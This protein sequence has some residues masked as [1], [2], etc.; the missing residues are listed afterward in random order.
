MPHTTMPNRSDDSEKTFL[1]ICSEAH[2]TIESRKPDL[3]PKVDFKILFYC[4]K[5]GAVVSLPFNKNNEHISR[6]GPLRGRQ[7]MTS[8][9]VGY[10]LTSSP[11]SRKNECFA[12]NFIP[13]VT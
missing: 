3:G 6:E 9:T 4:F 2:C 13:S 10:F 8:R 1:W 12:Y 11:L 5:A 7:L